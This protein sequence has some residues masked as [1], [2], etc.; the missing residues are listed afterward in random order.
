[1]SIDTT[2]Y[3][4]A[5]ATA[6]H[7]APAVVVSPGFG[8]SKDSVATDAR[9]LAAHGYVALAWS[10]RGF[11]RSTGKIALDAPDAEVAD[12]RV[13][14][15]RLGDR[16]DVLQDGPGDPRVALTGA[17]YG[18]GVSLLGA[19]LD[20]RVDATVPVITWNS[21]ETA[22]LPGGVFKAQYAALFF[23][24]GGSSS[25]GVCARFALRVCEA[26]NRL[27]QTGAGTAADRSLLAA[28]S[29][30]GVV[31]RITAPTLLVQGEDDTLFP[32]SESLATADALSAQGTPVH[33]AWLKGGHDLR[34]SVRPVMPRSGP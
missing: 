14:L 19:A 7:P 18:G 33:L 5:T 10:L 34:R 31:D 8:Q 4:P 20:H 11:G 1:M 24:S 30:A 32:L 9:D 26:Y 25:G 3:V 23:G 21:L 15:D 16:A 2:L 6:A 13:L 28:S 22:F 12:L 27:A 17:S 29:P